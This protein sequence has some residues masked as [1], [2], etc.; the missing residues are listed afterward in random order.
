MEQLIDLVRHNADLTMR[1]AVQK[2]E[3]GGQTPEKASEA[4]IE[5]LSDGSLA[6]DN[7]NYRL[8]LQG[9]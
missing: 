5:A 8:T 6:V 4:L 1:A 7:N 2:L 3:D 9:V